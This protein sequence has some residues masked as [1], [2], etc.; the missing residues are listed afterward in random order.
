[1][2]IAAR[3]TRQIH[4][5]RFLFDAR[6]TVA[7]SAIL[8]LSSISLL[9]SEKKEDVTVKNSSAN[10]NVVLV[11]AEVNGRPVQLECFMSVAHCKIP[12]EGSYLLVRLP[13]GEGAYMDCPNVYLYEKSIPPRPGTR[14]GEYCLLGE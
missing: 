3:I 8:L 9:G 12:K 11:N 2:E 1:M 7:I 4:N 13:S 10:K 6:A 5:C 14:I